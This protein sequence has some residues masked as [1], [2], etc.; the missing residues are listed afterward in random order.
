[1][2]FSGGS[3]TYMSLLPSNIELLCVLH[4]IAWLKGVFIFCNFASFVEILC[5]L[6]FLG[7]MHEPFFYKKGEKKKEKTEDKEKKENEEKNIVV[8]ARYRTPLLSFISWF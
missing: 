5:E 8:C 1:M 4:V 3:Y 6:L 2:P 7:K